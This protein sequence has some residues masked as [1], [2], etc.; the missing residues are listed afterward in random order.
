MPVCAEEVWEVDHNCFLWLQQSY[1]QEH[2]S[3]EKISRQSWRTITFVEST[4]L[5]RKENWQT[6][7]I[8]SLLQ[9]CVGFL[10]GNGCP[11]F[12]ANGDADGLIVKT[13]VEGASES[14]TVLVRDD[15]DVLVINYHTG[16][17]GR[18]F[19]SVQRRRKDSFKRKP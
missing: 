3:S 14:P 9:Q 6:R 18:D 15:S 17:D 10:E 13:S 8:K 11:L 19:F 1:Y 4:K 2:D 7:K 16:Q 5:Q 12:Q